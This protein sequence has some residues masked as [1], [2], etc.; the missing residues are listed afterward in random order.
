MH[1][2]DADGTLLPDCSESI[3]GDAREGK[4]GKLNDA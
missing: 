3:A 2:V 4:D 1:R